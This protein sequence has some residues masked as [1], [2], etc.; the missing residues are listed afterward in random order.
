MNT[1]ITSKFQAIRNIVCGI[2]FFLFSAAIVAE[3]VGVLKA[4]AFVGTDNAIAFTMAAAVYSALQIII[5]V[6]WFKHK[7]HRQA[8][9]VWTSQLSLFNVCKIPAISFFLLFLSTLLTQLI[10][11]FANFLPFFKDA[12]QDYNEM[13]LQQLN[14]LHPL[15]ILAIVILVPTAEELLF[16][17]FLIGELKQILPIRWACIF[18]AVIFSIA[19]WNLLQSAYTLVAGLALAFIYAWT[20]SIYYTIMLHA[21]FNLCGSVF[22]Y[23]LLRYPQFAVPYTFVMMILAILGYFALASLYKKS[24]TDSPVN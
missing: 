11:F 6:I 13:V 10:H 23:L 20:E 16:R 4:S 2:L 15:T 5:F 18:A 1:Q 7:L 24:A 12:V 9:Y 14:P 8:D 17:A 3:F 19:H 21:C 22:P